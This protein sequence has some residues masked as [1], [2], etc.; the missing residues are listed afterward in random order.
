MSARR[1]CR[2]CDASTEHIPVRVNAFGDEDEGVVSRVIFG[3]L[4]V[5]LSEACADNVLECV[6]C[7]RRRP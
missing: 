7:G 3:A 1:Y 2:S 4:S 6:E 5:G